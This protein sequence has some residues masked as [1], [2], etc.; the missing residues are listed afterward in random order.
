MI[1][2]RALLCSYKY[3]FRNVCDIW[4][5]LIWCNGFRRSEIWVHNNL[6]NHESVVFNTMSY[7]I[8]NHTFVEWF[9]HHINQFSTRDECRSC[10]LRV[11]GFRDEVP[12][13]T[14][15]RFLIYVRNLDIICEV[16][17]DLLSP[18]IDSIPHLWGEGIYA[19]VN[20]PGHHW[21]R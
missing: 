15:V 1:I 20:R 2:K 16:N 19:S 8:H 6:S 5:W 11:A 9:I 12:S 14:Q 4:F 21:F 7:T 13:L 10:M 17:S 3:K 18:V